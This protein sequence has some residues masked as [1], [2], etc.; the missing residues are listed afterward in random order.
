[1]KKVYFSV[2]IF[3][4]LIFAL[5]GCKKKA[6]GEVVLIT[7]IG[8]VEDGS[9]NQACYEGISDYC[10]AHG[11]PYT[12]YQPGDTDEESYNRM[13]KK[14][15]KN[16]AKVIICPGNLLEQSVYDLQKKYSR[17][18]F[19]LVDGEPHNEDYTD[20]SIADNVLSLHFAEAE[21][22]FLAGYSAV[23]D[24][25]TK[26][27]FMG[28]QMEDSIIRFGYGFCQGADYAAVEMGNKIEIE[29]CYTGTYLADPNVESLADNWYQSGTQVIFACGGEMGKSVMA[30]AD[31]NDGKVIGVDVDQSGMSHS[32]ITS[33]KKMI[34][35]AIVT[36]RKT[37][38]STVRSLCTPSNISGN[39]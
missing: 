10:T 33:A 30:S 34:A 1:M 29:Y 21:A 6:S 38:L 12:Y 23:R 32:V 37:I 9:F 35:N 31:E 18:K 17:V 20:M 2:I 5:T 8:T 14:A 4:C 16:R 39:M 26:L 3:S 27:G 28:G 13:I 7:D 22:G 19:I 36:V 25:Y 11:V 15:V 24:G